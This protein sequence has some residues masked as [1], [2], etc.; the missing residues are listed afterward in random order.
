M[1]RRSWFMFASFTLAACSLPNPGKDGELGNDR[2]IY[3]CV[4]ETDWACD[5]G[6]L[7]GMP[8]IA[9]GA[10]FALR[11]EANYTTPV[12]LTSR[13]VD[14]S[15]VS[16]PEFEAVEEGWAALA[17]QRREDDIVDVLHVKVERPGGVELSVSEPY[18][19]TYPEGPPRA[20]DPLGDALVTAESVDL[21]V[22]LTSADGQLLAGSLP[23]RWTVEP[24]GVVDVTPSS[25][26]NVVGLR[27]LGP[28]IAQVTAT[29]GDMWSATVSVDA[30]AAEGGGGAGGGDLG[31]G[32]AGEGGAGGA[33]GGA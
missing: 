29:I 24:E 33:G 30:S 27:V 31:G 20:W 21:R 8:T 17:S 9:L 3:E 11:T 18:T 23:T 25:G 7:E 5:D 6:E 32:G 26:D 12:S 19:Q 1:T 4:D 13:I 15:E 2:F 14:V 16:T 22:R 28:G 10:R